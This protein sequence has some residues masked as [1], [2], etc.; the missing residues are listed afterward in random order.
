MGLPV[1]L[2]SS[3]VIS[4]LLLQSHKY[5]E[6]IWEAVQAVGIVKNMLTK[7]DETEQGV[8]LFLANHVRSPVTGP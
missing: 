2:F 4:K 7:A 5:P 3:L 1:Q 8:E 6:S